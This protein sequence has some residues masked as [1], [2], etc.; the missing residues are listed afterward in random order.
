LLMTFSFG[1]DHG[2]NL[3]RHRFRSPSG[4]GRIDAQALT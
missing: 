2:T 3:R 1:E 4:K